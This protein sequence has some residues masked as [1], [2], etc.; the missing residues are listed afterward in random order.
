MIRNLAIA[1]LVLASPLVASAAEVRSGWVDIGKADLPT[2][3][4]GEIYIGR[5][6]LNRSGMVTG[7]LHGVLDREWEDPLQP[8]SFRDVYFDVLAD[9]AS[10]TVAFHSTWPVGPDQAGVYASDLR[11]PAPE[12]LG[13][14][15]LN[16][17][18]ARR[19]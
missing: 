10:G 2:F 7:Q 11:R 13:R 5:V 12:S 6:A 18:C 8:G 16:A 3:G 4:T 19:Q 15:L 17:A 14:R 9:C 1:S